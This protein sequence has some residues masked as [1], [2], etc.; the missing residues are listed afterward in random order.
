MKTRARTE[1]RKPRA[2]KRSI[3]T[4]GALGAVLAYFF[5]R[6][7]GPSTSL[8]GEGPGDCHPSAAQ[9]AGRPA[10]PQGRVRGLRRMATDDPCRS[11]GSPHRRRDAEA[12]EVE[13]ELFGK[14]DVDKGKIVVN[15][16]D[17]LVVLRGEVANSEQ[18]NELT[19]GVMQIPGAVGVENLLHLPQERP[20]NKAAA[21]EA[22]AS[23][24]E[25]A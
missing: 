25:S 7:R 5:D 18:M 21:R 20:P 13:T 24:A 9:E 23:A 22:S 1:T 2:K 17:G 15:V 19:Q 12:Q 6:G 11:R 14:P 16:E 4:T 3:L 8:Q 10:G